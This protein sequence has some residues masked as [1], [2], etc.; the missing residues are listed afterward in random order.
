MVIHTR[1]Q[2]LGP[3][4]CCPVPTGV[5]SAKVLQTLW[6]N[7]VTDTPSLW[8]RLA[9]PSSVLFPELLSKVVHGVVLEQDS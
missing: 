1:V 5:G 9:A 8:P 6:L 2:T 4:F 7:G 3:H